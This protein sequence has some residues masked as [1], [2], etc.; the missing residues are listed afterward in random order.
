MQGCG[1]GLRLHGFGSDPGGKPDPDP[2]LVV[3]TRTATE[4]FRL[5]KGKPD[6]DQTLNKPDPYPTK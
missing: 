3:K 2:T 5:L 4:G 1:S 6:P